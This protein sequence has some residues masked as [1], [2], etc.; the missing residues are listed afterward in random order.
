MGFER[1]YLI[2]IL[3]KQLNI[4]N[5]YLAYCCTLHCFAYNKI[6]KNMVSIKQVVSKLK[7]ST[8]ASNN[9]PN[10]DPWF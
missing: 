2:K 1:N 9:L 10:I 4:N 8:K 7:V 5:N 3:S 6:I